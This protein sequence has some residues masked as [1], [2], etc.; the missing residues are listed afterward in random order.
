MSGKLSSCFVANFSWLAVES[1]LMPRISVPW[2]ENFAF[3]SRKAV[4]SFVH[5]EVE[6]FG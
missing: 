1:L 5:P 3:R 6:S 2:R 4:A